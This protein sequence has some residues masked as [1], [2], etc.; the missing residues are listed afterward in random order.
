MLKFKGIDVSLY[1]GDVDWKRVRASGIDFAMIK[2]SQGRM[3]SFDSP[4]T[5]P[6]FER[7]IT[8]AV[9]AGL[10]VGTYHYLCARNMTEINE[11]ANYYITLLRPYKD[12]IK[13]WCAAD[14]ED[15]RYLGG[16]S[17]K[18]L[19]EAV[20]YFCSRLK[21]AGLRPMVYANTYWLNS[22]FTPPVG[23][24]LWEA[25]WSAA[26]SPARAKIWQYSSGGKVDGI[27]GA[28]DMNEGTDILGDAN[29]DG[30]VNL[31]D[32]TAIMKSIAGHGNKIDAGQAD[33]NNDGKVNLADAVGVLKTAAGRKH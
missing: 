32:A 15:E 13:L 25:N 3:P 23:V 31:T 14:V 26:S 7:N 1:Q 4:F 5:D 12:K 11:E 6:K 21:A 9:K 29:G 2:A 18:K 10:A 28:V 27:A 33:A 22:K 30:K 24:P 17:A 19:T 16:Y 8:E 20:S